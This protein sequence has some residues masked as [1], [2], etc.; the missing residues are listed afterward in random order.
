[1]VNPA[2]FYNTLIENKVDF[3]S[4]VP[5][6]LLK[7]LCAYITDHS[8]KE[9]NIIAPN[10]GCAVA[11][12]A[13]HYMATGDLPV[14]YMQNSGI[15]NAVNPLLSLA[16]EKVYQIPM[17]L[18]V[19][20]R[21]E[22]G[23]KDEPQHVK[24]GLVTVELLDAM[25]IPFI[26]LDLDERKALDQTKTLIT[27]AHQTLKP[28]AIVIRKDIFEPYKL[29]NKPKNDYTFSREQAL[30]IVVANL[31]KNPI[32]VSTTGKLSRELFELRETRNESHEMDFLT[33]G[34]MGHSSSIALGIA[35]AKP[36]R[37]V[38][39]FDGDGAMIMHMGALSSVGYLKPKNYLH[40]LFNNGAHE[41]VGG[42]PTVGFD[43]DF[44]KIALANGYSH[45]ATAQTEE[46]ITQLLKELI[47]ID[48]PT[49]LEIKINQSSRDDLG[50]PTTTTVE[51]K[52]N[53]MEYVYK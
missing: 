24:Q 7:S 37:K 8:P 21:G 4:G 6:S 53:F 1:M 2:S 18:I 3:F 22:P 30:K 23:V 38:V 13:G 42:Q 25:G 15:G 47:L 40:I 14:V 41:S 9:R 52:I 45:V 19:G 16:D 34:S 48:G 26:V 20:W 33:V 43:I 27:Q 12:A 44:Q 5:D 39:C 31:P 50:R 49:L 10:E 35:I 32:I 36:L 46:Q 28:H 11:L 29:V 51:N 17:I